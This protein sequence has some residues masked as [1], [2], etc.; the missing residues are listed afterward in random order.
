MAARHPAQYTDKQRGDIMVSAATRGWDVDKSCRHA[1]ADDLEVV[2]DTLRQWMAKGDRA[3]GAAPKKRKAQV[4]ASIRRSPT[5]LV[6]D[7]LRHRRD[8]AADLREL[9]ELLSNS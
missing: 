8:A 4:V 3:T 2:Y 9:N 5:M 1:L 7:I 6:A